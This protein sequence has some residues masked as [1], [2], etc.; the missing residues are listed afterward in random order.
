M[1]SEMLR[2][3]FAF[4]FAWLIQWFCFKKWVVYSYRE[5]KLFQFVWRCDDNSKSFATIR[6]EAAAS[7]RLHRWRDSTFCLGHTLV[8]AERC[9]ETTQTL[10]QKIQRRL[11]MGSKLV[12]LRST[13]RF[14]RTSN[15]KFR[16]QNKRSSKAHSFRESS[17][18]AVENLAT[19]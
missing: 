7:G 12:R 18:W 8:R 2:H 17:F 11:S 1:K 14:P 3:L 15:V 6:H 16:S 9:F 4:M 5:R 19:A 10:I 13:Q